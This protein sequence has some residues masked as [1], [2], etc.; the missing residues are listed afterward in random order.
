MLCTAH[1]RRGHSS[2]PAC[3]VPR[4]RLRRY[5]HYVTDANLTPEKGSG[6]RRAPGVRDVATLAGV[7]P[8]TVSRVLNN[9]PNVKPATRDRV[10]HAIGQL[11][12]RVNAAARSLITR[13]SG[14][15]GLVSFDTS[16]YGPSSALFGI[17]QAARDAG[18]FVS[19]VS[20]KVINR[21]SLYDAFGLLHN[22]DPEGIIVVSPQRSSALALR[23]LAQDM[24]MVA[25]HAI[26]EDGLPM[27]TVDHRGGARRA[28]QHLLDL[29]HET[30]WHISGSQDWLDAT[31]RE[32]G[33]RE[34]LEDS[35]R[36]VPEVVAGDWSTESGY[37]AGLQLA[38]N[39]DVTA[40]FVANDQM[41][42][43]VLGALHKA[44]LRVP[45]DVSVVG[46]DDT[47]QAAYYAPPLTTVRQDYE[48]LVRRSMDL[49]LAQ[50]NGENV[51]LVNAPVATDLILREST[52]R[53][54][55][56][57]EQRAA[58]RSPNA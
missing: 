13:K 49:M 48:T 22:Q 33:W 3:R 21:K 58:G 29:G 56:R 51:P 36:R 32:R 52:A 6:P 45:E 12:Y 35:G 42:L 57:R 34:A 16:L 18:Y 28:T 4:P 41:A 11:N 8:Q 14:I 39:P 47:P 40:I 10:N 24:P 46:F 5:G 38:E 20:L 2:P 26:P 27:I 50:V 23:E 1:E 15:L 9:N 30:V 55:P 19:L 54:G 37:M 25:V 17:A 53:P 44:G 43:G 7:S 31:A